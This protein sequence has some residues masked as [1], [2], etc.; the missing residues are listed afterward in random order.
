MS[1]HF[2]ADNLKFPGDDRRLDLT[3][4]FG[5]ARHV[6]AGP[7]RLAAGLHSDPFFADVEGA[8]HGFAWLSN[9]TIPRPASSRTTTCWPTSPTSARPT[10]ARNPTWLMKGQPPGGG[11]RFSCSRMCRLAAA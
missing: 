6:Q 7:V 4:L 5:T 11:G 2:S 10:L 8:L 3:D 1:N 9:G